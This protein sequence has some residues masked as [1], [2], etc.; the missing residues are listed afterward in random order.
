MKILAVGDIHTKTWIIDLVESV[1]ENYDAVVFV[2]DYADDFG[3]SAEKSIATWEKLWRLNYKHP[4]KVKLVLGNH[5]YIYVTK[6]PHLQSGYNYVTQHLIDLPENR[7]L[8]D[9]LSSLPLVI[10]LEGVT[11]AHAGIDERWS[12][13][14]DVSSIWDDNS[15]IWVRPD[16][17]QYKKI[18]Q[19]VGHT[20]Q[21]TVNEVEPGIW[22]IDTF[23]T[24]SDG[25]PYG[26]GTMLVITDGKKF[27]KT[28]I[29]A[30]HN[31]TSSVEGGV[32][33]PHS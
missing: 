10:E 4:D 6:T 2:G 24:H 11:Y 29:N 21:R 18:K 7:R 19:V 31:N 22:L 12:G 1:I 28:K 5:D 14:E 25:S 8:R 26:D 3:A 27:E 33:R 20:P 23:S 15:P 17:S 30:N 32:P 9:W 13:Q 16:W